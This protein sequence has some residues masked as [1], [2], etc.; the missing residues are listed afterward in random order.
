MIRRFFNLLYGSVPAEFE[1]AFPLQE[2]VERL[3]ATTKRTI[4]AALFQEAAVGR[5]T[6]QRVCLQR[7]IPFV[8]NS[9]KPFFIGSFRQVGDKVVLSG[10]FT[11]QR[12]VKVGMTVWFGFIL[13]WTLDAFVITLQ[14]APTV[15]YFPL[16]G[17]GMLCFGFF[18]VFAGKWFARNDTERLSRVIGEA[19]SK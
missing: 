18:L 11:M 10:K 2:S 7:V 16:V 15:W 6:E 1:S 14:K 12:F 9:F 5:V 4:F 13:F 17:V 19:L 3:R 8:G